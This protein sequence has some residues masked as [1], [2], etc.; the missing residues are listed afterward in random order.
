MRFLKHLLHK[1]S[2]S[3]LVMTIYRPYLDT[4]PESK[5]FGIRYDEITTFV[6]QCNCCGHTWKE[7]TKGKEVK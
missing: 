7:T 3:T 2:P 5:E 6:F 1:N 4:N